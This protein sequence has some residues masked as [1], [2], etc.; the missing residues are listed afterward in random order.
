MSRTFPNGEKP[1]PS[2]RELSAKLMKNCTDR[3]FG[4]LVFGGQVI[5][6][7]MGLGFSSMMDPQNGV[8][9]PVVSQFYM[10]FATLLFLLLI[11][12]SCGCTAF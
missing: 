5:A 6:Y 1:M 10:I 12:V 3:L 7:S 8:Q 9:V 2:S 4:A 11:S